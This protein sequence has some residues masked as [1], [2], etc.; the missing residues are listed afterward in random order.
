MQNTENLDKKFGEIILS[1]AYKEPKDVEAALMSLADEGYAEAAL[2]VAL[3]CGHSSIADK[4][5]QKALEL[6]DKGFAL[7]ES[8]SI[9][10]PLSDETPEPELRAFDERSYPAAM[11]CC[12]E[13]MMDLGQICVNRM[14]YTEAVF[15]TALANYHCCLPA[16]MM[17]VAATAICK[18]SEEYREYRPSNHEYFTEE[19]YKATNII[20]RS[21]AEQN[22]TFT[23][24]D[25]EELT[26][27]AMNC[28]PIAA[29]ALADHYHTKKDAKK[30]YEAC[31]PLM[32]KGDALASHICADI[33]ISG[34]SAP[35]SKFLVGMDAAAQ[36]K[37]L[38]RLAAEKGDIGAMYTLGQYEIQQGS[39]EMAAAWFQKAVNRGLGEAEP[40]LKYLIGTIAESERVCP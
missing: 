25:I 19:Q 5:L 29:Y 11:H 18:C 7:W 14:Q 9:L 26:D 30:A 39:S 12:V 6:G 34:F 24:K 33:I 38:Y 31:K 20:I 40:L 32:E 8:T 36:A 23:E 35:Q 28:V 13:A 22:R 3:H 16:E 37:P 4:Y 21:I 27:M 10:P 15:W 1:Q 17:M 2:T